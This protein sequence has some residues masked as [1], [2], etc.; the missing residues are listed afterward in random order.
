MVK[1]RRLNNAVGQGGMIA[2]VHIRVE[3]DAMEQLGPLTRA[4]IADAPFNVLAKPILDQILAIRPVPGR[5]DIRLD[6]KD[7]R[8]DACMADGV[9]KEAFKRLLVDRSEV[10]ARSGVIPLRPR[11][12]ARRRRW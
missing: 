2:T 3:L 8:L 7:P 4:A 5:D 6:P 12:N 9:H 11:Q 10:D 1:P